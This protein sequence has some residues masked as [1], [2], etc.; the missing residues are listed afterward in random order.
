M[1]SQILKTWEKLNF[2]EKEIHHRCSLVKILQN[3]LKQLFHKTLVKICFCFKSLGLLIL[4]V[5]HLYFA[6][7][8]ESKLY[9]FQRF[10]TIIDTSLIDTKNKKCT[11]SKN[12]NS[13][14]IFSSLHETVGTLNL[15]THFRSMH[16]FLSILCSVQKHI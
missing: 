14:S 2:T 3:N 10:I 1:H 9:L 8:I 15:L 12:K 13:Y 16:R 4:I 5:F 7:N 11:K 6:I